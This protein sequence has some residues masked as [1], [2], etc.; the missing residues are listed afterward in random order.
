MTTGRLNKKEA[1]GNKALP[2]RWWQFET[3]NG[4]TKYQ[5]GDL[6]LTSWN[7]PLPGVRLEQLGQLIPGCEWHISPLGR[8]Y[9]VNHNTRA[10]SW[11]QPTVERPVGS[12]TPECI[13]EGHSECI[14]SLGCVGSNVM[15]ASGDGSIS[16]WRR[17][18]GPAGEPWRTNRS[19]VG[20]LA[21]SPDQTMVVS[22][23]ENG[24]LRL[25]NM[26]EGSMV[27]CPWRGHSA[28]VTCLDWSPDAREIASGSQDGTIRRWNPDTRR[29]IAPP[30]KTSHDQVYAV[31]YS[32]R[33]D[34][35]A[36]GGEDD[37]IR[38]WSN[39]SKLL[40]EIKGHDGSVNLLCWSKDGAYIFSGSDDMT[41]RIWESIEGQELFALRGH[42]NSV[43]SVCLTSDE[44][45]LVSASTD[46][47]VRI[48]DLET[49]EQIGDPLW[50]DDELFALA[51]SSD[52]PYIA[53]AGKDKK[54][55][56]WSIEAALQ[57]GGNQVC[58][59]RGAEQM[60]WDEAILDA[61]KVIES[62]PSSHLGYELKHA[63]LHGAQRYDESLTAFQIMLSKLDHTSDLQARKLRQQYLSP[64]DAEVEI[65]QVIHAQTEN[66]PLRLFDTTTGLLHD[67]EAQINVFKTST[68][69]KELLSLTLMMK[70]ADRRLERIEEVVMTYFRYAMLSHRLEGKEPL[71]HEIWDE[72]VRSA[73]WPV[74]LGIVGLGVIHAASTR[75]TTSS[76]K[77]QLTPCV[78]YRHSALTIIYLS[79][80]SPSSKSGALAGSAWNKRGWTVQE[81]LAPKVVIFYQKDW[82][83][84][85][86]DRTPN[87]KESLTI[88]QELAYATSI[89]TRTLVAFRP[90]VGGAREKLQWVSTR[91]TTLQEDIAYSLF[92]IFGVHLLVNYGEKKQ[93]ALGRVLQ[94]I[95]AHSGDIT[96]LDWVGK[97]SE[98]NSCLPAGITSYEV[99][100]FAPSSPSEREIQITVSTLRNIAAFELALKLYTLLH[101]TT[102]PRFTNCRL[103]LSCIIFPVRE[104]T[105]EGIYEVRQRG[106]MTC[107]LRQAD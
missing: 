85:L 34:E 25:W 45:H 8:S 35:F 33:G 50:H 72:A 78:W 23:S 98:F 24:R 48:W 89:D 37:I 59:N 79:D 36:S 22:G 93:N 97:S 12:L 47:S 28:P 57:Q 86:D 43:R 107:T 52:E 26:K 46:Y 4:N 30:I 31:K 17:D 51:I 49:N 81:F 77:N 92:G 7:R 67:R 16:Q 84:Y 32:P 3:G 10:T 91:V 96:A 1:G 83:L 41:I 103:H 95:I 105:R 27:G 94:E 106:L 14:W 80:V 90:E 11:K 73:E 62:N 21:V 70:H 102:A 76:S 19:A 61:Q 75:L 39:D 88:M 100:P 40:I 65:R 87:H 63:A 74:T 2:P 56:I 58:P 54:V 53:S 42:T 44:R 9:F 101:N 60:R 29:E 68:Q 20:S 6:I 64:S 13:I 15:S 99:P 71:L 18:G 104:V 38:V 69:Y 66:I 55:Y 5:D 82:S